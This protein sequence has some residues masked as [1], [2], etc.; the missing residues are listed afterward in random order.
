M[1]APRS[2]VPI[3]RAGQRIECAN[4][5]TFGRLGLLAVTASMKIIVVTTLAV[6][7]E[8]DRGTV[9]VAGGLAVIGPAKALHDAVAAPHAPITSLLAALPVSE[10][11]RVSSVFIGLEAVRAGVTP[12][13]AADEALYI[14]DVGG[15]RRIGRLA[16]IDATV[17]RAGPGGPLDYF[18]AAE[19]GLDSPGA[20]GVGD[21]GAAVATGDGRLLGIVV[22]ARDGRLLVAPCSHLLAKGGP[23]GLLP[24]DA[25]RHDLAVQEALARREVER[26]RRTEQERRY[27]PRLDHDTGRGEGTSSE[28]RARHREI[29]ELV[30]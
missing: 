16:A 17:R 18:G 26:L 12:R 7:P 5:R 6:V 19:I 8:G 29:L 23:R 28:I 4:A 2:D 10:A 1:A 15:P 27:D 13:A 22:G 14:A 9:D 25:S 11:C 3:L 24:F 30:S 21:A 20:A